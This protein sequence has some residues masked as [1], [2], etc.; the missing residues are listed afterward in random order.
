MIIDR[1]K[2][3]YLEKYLSHC[4]SIYWKFNMDCPGVLPRHL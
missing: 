1:V 2:V 4:H 3:K